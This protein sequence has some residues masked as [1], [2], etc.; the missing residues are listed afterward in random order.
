MLEPISKTR[1]SEVAVRRIKDFIIEQAMQSGDQL[2]AERQL[3]EALGISRTSVRE[4]LRVLEIMGVIEV[5]PGSG[6]YVKDRGGD[7]ALPLGVWLPKDYETLREHYEIRLLLEPRAASLAAQH[8]T[9]ELI[10]AM[11]EQLA[12]FP[13]CVEEGDLAGMILADTEFHRLLGQATENKILSLLMS[14]IARYMHDGWQGVL[15]IPGR[16]KKTICEHNKV[17][18]AIKCGESDLA[19]Q[20]MEEHLRNALEDLEAANQPT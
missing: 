18:E 13:V 5:K 10:E 16:A 1:L 6:S 15:P 8:A 7:L 3:S 11:E 17:F 19:R 12:R 14:T 20:A 2:P 4:A 9:P